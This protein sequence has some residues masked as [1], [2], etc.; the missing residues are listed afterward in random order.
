MKTAALNRREVIFGSVSTVSLSLLGLS[1]RKALA[2][3][4]L[5]GFV[6]F[7]QFAG[8]VHN[9]LNKPDVTQ[10][11]P[12][13]EAIFLIS[14][15]V[16]II[17]DMLA[18]VLNE[19]H[20]IRNYMETVFPSRVVDEIDV[21]TIYSA[22]NRYN[23]L[24]NA[25]YN[26]I[27]GNSLDC[28]IDN[29][30]YRECIEQIY[31][32]RF[33]NEITSRISNA[34]HSIE[35]QDNYLLVPTVAATIPVHIHAMTMSMEPESIQIEELK[36]YKVWLAAQKRKMRSEFRPIYDKMKSIR[37]KYYRKPMVFT[38]AKNR[39]GQYSVRPPGS[40]FKENYYISG[41]EQTRFYVQFE[42][43][44][45][46]VASIAR[47]LNEDGLKPK[48]NLK[49]MVVSE[50]QHEKDRYYLKKRTVDQHPDHWYRTAPDCPQRV[51]DGLDAETM[52]KSLRSDEA[53][54]NQNQLKIISLAVTYRAC[55]SALA[56]VSKYINELERA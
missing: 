39:I 36:T 35:S 30:P 42:E 43:L 28:P 8:R 16:S 33:R 24:L 40:F 26:D 11:S 15:Q 25:Y 27:K 34:W 52:R 53:E 2:S 54:Y 38:C 37:F 51:Y 5:A 18:D 29:E 50:K 56:T 55:D 32:P 6:T 10:N 4:T 3:P 49:H 41:I 45:G 9:L 14:K 21:R 47:E 22:I 19:I 12:S 17:K 31:R 13:L 7:A 20:E 23:V 48:T 44:S 1:S 46:D